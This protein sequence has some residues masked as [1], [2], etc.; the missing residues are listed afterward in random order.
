M[1]TAS[2]R[3]L[4]SLVRR[5]TERIFFSP[6]LLTLLICGGSGCGRSGGQNSMALEL[7]RQ[8][9]GTWV[10]AGTGSG[11]AVAPQEAGRLKFFTGSHW[12]IVQSDPKTGEVAFLHGGTYTLAGDEMIQKVEYAQ[13]NTMSQVGQSF[14]FKTS[15]QGDTLTQV[16]VGN[17][18]NEVWKRLP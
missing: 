13:H 16:G 5:V 8:L 15:V 17:R 11:G 3:I 10:L 12:V 6:V 4:D 2:L 7:P 18:W 14:K 9:V 1:I